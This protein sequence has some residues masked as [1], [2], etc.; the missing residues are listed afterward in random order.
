M[1]I[2]KVH[3]RFFESF[4]LSSEIAIR[5]KSIANQLNEA[6]E[7]KNPLF[8]SVLN[9][10]FIFAADLLRELTIANEITFV[11]IA[12]YQGTESTENITEL[13][14]FSDNITDRHLIIIED[15]ID[16]GLSMKHIVTQVQALNPASVIIVTLLLKP[17]ALKYPIQI[18]YTGFEIENKFVLGYGL[19]YDGQGR[20]LPHIFV[21]K[22]DTK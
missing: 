8:V 16:T 11:K 17:T 9:G 19:D 3:D 14:G 2:I 4:I 7:G 13:I 18:A 22:S 20:N 21:E 10:A 12:S 15:I 5:V 1:A 6:Y